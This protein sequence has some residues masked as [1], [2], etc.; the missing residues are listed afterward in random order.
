[1][2]LSNLLDTNFLSAKLRNESLKYFALKCIKKE[3]FAKREV[4]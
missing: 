2:F 3:N 1:M 4:K